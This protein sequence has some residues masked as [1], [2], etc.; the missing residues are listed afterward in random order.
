MRAKA[1]TKINARRMF[2]YTPKVFCRQVCA[3]LLAISVS[4]SPLCRVNARPTSVLVPLRTSFVPF[5]PALQ[6]PPESVV[7]SQKTWTV[8][9]R[10]ILFASLCALPFLP[11]ALHREWPV[12]RPA[13]RSGI[14]KIGFGRSPPV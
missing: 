12:L 11:D 3:L 9:K 6:L 5:G 7:S 10:F 4:A 13:L 14:R 8:N 1:A 2:F